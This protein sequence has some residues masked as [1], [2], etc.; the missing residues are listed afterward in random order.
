MYLVDVI[1]P[2]HRKDNLLFDAI[3][4]VA[5]ELPDN[6]RIIAV[7]DSGADVSKEDIGLGPHDLVIYSAQKGY[8]GAMATGISQIDS[9]YVSFLDSDDLCGKDRLNLLVKKLES[10]LGDYC[11]GKLIRIGN[12]GKLITRRSILGELPTEI[13]TRL[14]FLLGAHRADSTVMMKSEIATKYW[15]VHSEA[16]PMFADYALA[17]GLPK[18]VKFLHEPRAEYLYRSHAGQMSRDVE[19]T[20][21]WKTIHEKWVDNYEFVC[22]QHGYSPKKNLDP[23]ITM[24]I[25]FPSALV[26]LN[27]KDRKLAL[28]LLEQ[29]RS[30][31]LVATSGLSSKYLNMFINRRGLLISPVGSF[32]YTLAAPGFL[33]DLCI[34][35]ATGMRPRITKPKFLTKIK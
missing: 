29:I 27:R 4:S 6:S 21:P 35:F 26:R 1:I 5:Q 20:T 22:A 19:I 18:S 12:N 8:L 10:S 33:L 25:A 17:L 11:S 23:L 34:N 2:F 30:I 28:E 24:A 13:S 31:S 9:K 15:S 7:N 32:R 16:P 14:C 3:Q